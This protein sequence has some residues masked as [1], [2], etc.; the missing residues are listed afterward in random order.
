MPVLV[1]FIYQSYTVNNCN[2]FSHNVVFRIYTL[3]NPRLLF[4][5]MSIFNVIS[6]A[7]ISWNVEET[8]REPRVARTSRLLLFLIY[9]CH[10]TVAWI[11]CFW[12]RH[13]F[14]LVTN[15]YLHFQ[16]LPCRLESNYRV[17]GNVINKWKLYRNNI[18][19][20]KNIYTVTTLG[21]FYLII[22]NGFLSKFFYCKKYTIHFCFF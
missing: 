5:C 15:A 17:N 7:R 10:I 16:P 12:I 8:K 4:L 20:L 2:Y 6:Y 19:S 22:D 21:F 11:F 1:F 14:C 9:I 3:S 18:F 13:C